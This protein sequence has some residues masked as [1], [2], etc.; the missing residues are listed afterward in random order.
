MQRAIFCMRQLRPRLPIFTSRR[1]PPQ[2][3]IPKHHHH[4]HYHHH[5]QQHQQQQVQ[6]QQQQQQEEKMAASE[7]GWVLGPEGRRPRV[8]CV[9]GTQWGDEGK[10]KLVD[11]LC[12][13]ADFCCR[14]NGGHNAGHQLVVK[15]EKKS[16]HI[17]PCGILHAHTAAVLG[18]GVALHLSQLIK[19]IR[20]A[21]TT[22][23][24][25]H[26]T[27]PPPQNSS[28]TSSDN[29]SQQQEQQQQRE[30]AEDL[31]PLP[32]SVLSRVYISSR[33][34]LLF[35]LH[36]A[37]D[38]LQERR[39]AAGGGGGPLGTTLK[40]IGPCYSSKA[41]RSGVRAG[42]LLLDFESFAARY[43]QLAAELRAQHGDLGVDEEAELERHRAYRQLLGSRIVDTCALLHASLAAGRRLLLEGAN[44][45][46]LDLDLG[47]YPYVTSSNT[48]AANA[49]MGLGLPPRSLDL[50]VGVVKAYSTRVGGG[51]MPTELADGIGD[52]L[53]SQGGEFGVTTGRPRRCGW[54]D[55]PMLL[56]ALR[57]NGFDCLCLS[58][59]DVLRGLQPLLICTG[60]RDRT[61]GLVKDALFYPS[62][63]AEFDNLLPVY[64]QLDGWQEDLAA[65]RTLQDLP[66][67]AQLYVHRV[68][69][70]LG[71]P[72]W[73]IGVGADREDM[74]TTYTLP[75]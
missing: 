56:H 27:P 64:E 46:L 52:R 19:E 67:N 29:N 5:H 31:S 28:S 24:K 62:T 36:K 72:F 12:S 37:A 69:Q 75:T 68:Q 54:L 26:N 73:W 34:H 66:K 35:E 60:Y 48:T 6:Q 53:R 3:A 71:V 2:A 49:C 42:E 23:P 41:S 11:Y 9:L 15:G 51:P 30:E 40:G 33:C 21:A 18:N 20:R 22:P 44:A 38:A 70:L 59:L 1:A 13:H 63:S 17:L 7:V 45:A 4:Y 14:F 61:T 39:K 65:C 50:V 57:A 10:G 47:T 25:Q 74:I 58:K 32:E 43:K 8:V 55:I 16:F